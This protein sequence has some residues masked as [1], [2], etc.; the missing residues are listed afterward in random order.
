[1]NFYETLF[2]IHPAL[3]SG[4]LKDILHSI[5]ENLKNLG[6]K[7]LSIEVWGKKRLAYLIDKQKYGTYV[8]LQ[9]SGNG[10]CTRDFEIELQ[11]N[12]NVLSYL[13]TSISKAEVVEQEHDIETQIAGHSRESDVAK[14]T[15]ENKIAESENQESKNDSTQEAITTDEL[16]N[17]EVTTSEKDEKTSEEETNINVEKNNSTESNEE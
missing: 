15:D 17:T 2:I 7:T 1:M 14:K 4:H 9:F 11:H 12:A 3:E 6:C 16:P 8:Q 13:T 5:D 10:S